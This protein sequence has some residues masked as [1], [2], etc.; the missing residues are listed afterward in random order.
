M[1]GEEKNEKRG[2][3]ISKVPFDLCDKCHGVN[4]ESLT[5]DGVYVHS[6]LDN[7]KEQ[8]KFCHLCRLTFYQQ[9]IKKT[10]TLDRYEIKLEIDVRQVNTSHSDHLDNHLQ[11]EKVLWISNRHIRPHEFPE[12][13]LRRMTKEGHRE[14]K[15]PGPSRKYII[16]RGRPHLCYTL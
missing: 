13:Q 8:A 14:F 15:P 7:I 11:F 2:A 5:A 1:N 9:D 16:V 4:I 6:T 10:K 12:G 3:D